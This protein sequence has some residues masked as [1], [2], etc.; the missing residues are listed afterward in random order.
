MAVALVRRFWRD[1]EGADATEYALLAALIAV[2]IITGASMLGT[3]IGSLFQSLAGT[4]GGA[5]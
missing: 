5:A 2:A 1:E 3:S 4:I